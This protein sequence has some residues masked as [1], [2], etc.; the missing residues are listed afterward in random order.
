M[1]SRRLSASA[2]ACLD[3]SRKRR[4]GEGRGPRRANT[5]TAGGGH[6]P[7][8]HGLGPHESARGVAH[9]PPCAHHLEKPAKALR[10][11]H[12]SRGPKDGPLPRRSRPPSP[13]LRTAY[14]TKA[15]TKAVSL[16]A[17]PPATTPSHAGRRFR[18]WLASS[19]SVKELQ[20]LI[21]IIYIHM[22]VNTIKPESCN[23]S[24]RMMR[25]REVIVG[26]PT[27]ASPA[28]DPTWSRTYTRRAV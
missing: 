10:W 22:G 9:A 17:P 1:A 7:F 20:L 11:Y 24:L 3:A 25:L 13:V 15:I 14:S 18:S 23:A 2:H 12:I 21:G 4:K 26:T 8:G 28:H 27:C 6:D 16:G 19:A 5:E